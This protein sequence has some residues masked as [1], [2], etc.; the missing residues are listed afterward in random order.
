[1]QRTRTRKQGAA[2]LGGESRRAPQEVAH[3][4]LV[5]LITTLVTKLPINDVA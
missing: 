2:H 4:E 3:S 5:N 1:M